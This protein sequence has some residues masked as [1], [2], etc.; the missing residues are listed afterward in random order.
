[1][2]RDII[3][4]VFEPGTKLVLRE[5]S[6]RYGVGVIPLREALSR[7]AMS[8]FVDAED[9][10]GFRV[11]GVSPA[12]LTDL[13]NIRKQLEADALRDSIEHGDINWET[14]LMTASHRLSR[15]PMRL[16]GSEESLNPAWEE[17]HD[18]FHETLLS[19]AESLWLRRLCG[20]LREQ[21]ARYRQLSVRAEKSAVRDVREEHQKI[22]DAALN[23]DAA[24]ACGLLVKH[25]EKT[26]ELAL[27]K[28]RVF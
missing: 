18:A 10:R 22:V 7:L 12:E 21:T 23:R 27:A 3:S 15:I 4:G 17:A 20:L 16:E 19:G 8:G 26:T 5:L 13:T 1:V 6:E 14:D 25:F 28:S 2:R 24:T 11:A 9:Q